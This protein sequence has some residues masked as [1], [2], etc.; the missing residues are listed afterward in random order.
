MVCVDWAIE[1]TG[2]IKVM[3]MTMNAIKGRNFFVFMI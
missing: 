3:A 2:R 1:L